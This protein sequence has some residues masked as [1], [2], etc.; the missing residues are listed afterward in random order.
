[1]KEGVLGR[2]NVTR[3]PW[4]VRKHRGVSEEHKLR[5]GRVRT[6]LPGR[7]LRDTAEDSP[8]PV[9]PQQSDWEQQERR[10]LAL[11]NQWILPSTRH[12]T[13]CAMLEQS[14]DQLIFL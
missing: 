4:E 6:R 2:S 11:G 5:E 9:R 7:H 12:R 13:P 14:R 10:I 3:E 1:M 8:E